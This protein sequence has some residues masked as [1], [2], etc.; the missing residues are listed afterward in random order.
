MRRSQIDVIDVRPP[1]TETG[2]NPRPLAGVAPKL[3]PVSIQTR[4]CR[5]NY[6]CDDKKAGEHDLPMESFLRYR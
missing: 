2:R 6:Y 3:P 4:S 5:A 1:H